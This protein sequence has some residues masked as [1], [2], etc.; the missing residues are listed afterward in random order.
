[1]AFRPTSDHWDHEYARL[2]NIGLL[3]YEKVPHG[4]G[5]YCLIFMKIL[6]LNSRGTISVPEW[7]LAF[8]NLQLSVH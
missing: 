1:M 5:H 8:D 3:P 4:C 2:E 6:D 7:L